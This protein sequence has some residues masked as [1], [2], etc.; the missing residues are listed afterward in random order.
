M[1]K[2]TGRFYFKQTSNG[3][4]IG[5]FSNDQSTGI[6][7]ESADLLGINNI[8]FIGTYNSTWRENRTPSFAV[9]EITHKPNTNNKIFTLQW[10][11][12]SN[13]D[14]EGMLC[15]DILIGDY[16]SV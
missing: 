6:S 16:R 8:D 4:L 15:D 10:R 2:V 13:F 11:G 1:A 12:V 9:L 14:G 5:E 7:T 3:N